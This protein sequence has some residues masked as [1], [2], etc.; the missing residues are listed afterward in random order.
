M[1]PAAARD[2]EARSS[3]TLVMIVLTAVT[4]LV[5]AVSLLALGPAF[6]A[7]QTGNLLFLSFGA[8]GAGHLPTLGPAVSLAAFA[9]GVVA[10][11]RLEAAVQARGRRWFVVALAAEGA[12]IACAAVVGWG[13][14]PHYGAPTG[15]QMAVT[16]VLACAMGM[17]NVTSMR[18]GVPGMPTTLAT[19][20]LTAFLGS[21]PGHDSA[22]GR[23]TATWFRRGASLLALFTGGAV[24]AAMVGAGLPVNQ[25][26][27]PAALLVLAL[28]AYRLTRPRLSTA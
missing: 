3:L 5:E 27:A 25:L 23:D 6:T 28:A 16:G 4:G 2:E 22:F 26:L 12:L 20:T 11:A 21:V 9:V 13:L 24:G 7:M 10:G 8:A 15:R 14:A 19:R 18:V 17:R 1:A